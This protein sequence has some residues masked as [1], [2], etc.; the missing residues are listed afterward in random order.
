MGKKRPT[1]VQ[2]EQETTTGLEVVE[3]SPNTD[4]AVR[5]IRDQGVEGV[6]YRIV[7]VLLSF[8]VTRVQVARTVDMEEI[9]RISTP[10]ALAADAPA[11]DGSEPGDQ[12]PAGAV[13]AS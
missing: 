11:L 1:I 10:A 3:T 4:A 2:I 6:I 13:E 12:D 9:A 5:W 7:R 8:Q